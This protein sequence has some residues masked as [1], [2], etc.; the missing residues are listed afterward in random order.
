MSATVHGFKYYTYVHTRNDTGE[1]FYVG[2][3]HGE[4]AF[5]KD[6]SN[7]HWNNTTAKHGR[8]V[9]IIAYWEDEAFAFAHEK[10]LIAEFRASGVALVNMTDGGDGTSGYKQSPAHIEARRL[11]N[12]GKVKSVET[13]QRIKAGFCGN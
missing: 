7:M 12:M 11:A 13:R 3:G 6:R 4:R 1:V 8:T 2:K 10:E 9:H 5:S